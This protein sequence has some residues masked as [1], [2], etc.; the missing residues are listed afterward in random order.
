MPNSMASSIRPDTP[1][2]QSTV[3]A[4]LVA[5]DGASWLP[6]TLIAI[7]NQSR[8]VDRIIAIDTG[9]LD[10]SAKLISA[11]GITV[12][13]APRDLGF[14]DAVELA[15]AQLPAEADDEWIWLLHDD[16]APDEGALAELLQAGA[17]RHVSPSAGTRRRCTRSRA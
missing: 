2:P 1:S 16:C 14:G 13:P 12:I 17:E 6:Q 9:S 5:H 15:L 7:N 4:V 11:A 10:T 8:P 3:T